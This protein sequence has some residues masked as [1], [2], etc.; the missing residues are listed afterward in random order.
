MRKKAGGRDKEGGGGTRRGGSRVSSQR[1]SR[2]HSDEE[3]D[4]GVPASYHT[5]SLQLLDLMHTL[6][7]RAASIYSS[8][9]EEQRHLEAAGRRIEADSQTLWSSCWCPLLQ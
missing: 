3:E 5:V 4:E 6:H 7:T 9:A 8:W 1:P 2:S